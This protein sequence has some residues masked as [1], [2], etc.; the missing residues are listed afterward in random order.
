MNTFGKTH[1]DLVDETKEMLE[2]HLNE[3]RP[4]DETMRRTLLELG[5]VLKD[6]SENHN[7]LPAQINHPVINEEGKILSYIR[8]IMDI[9]KEDVVGFEE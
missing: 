1:E 7:V 9:D 6:I 3:E 2:K 8:V 4:D 5:D